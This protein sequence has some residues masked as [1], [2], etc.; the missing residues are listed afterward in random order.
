MVPNLCNTYVFY[1]GKVFS[2]DEFTLFFFLKA[3]TYVEVYDYANI[4]IPTYTI[5]NT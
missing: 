1:H 5:V 2:I 4:H 3:M